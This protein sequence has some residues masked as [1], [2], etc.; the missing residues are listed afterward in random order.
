[1]FRM[2]LESNFPDLVK[3]IDRLGGN[4]RSA[5]REALNRSADDA[6]AA[7]SLEIDRAFDR[8]VNFTRKSLRVYYANTSNLVVRL[9]FRQRS[10]DEDKL[11]AFPQIVGGKRE[12][13]PFEKRLRAIGVLPQGW[14]A[15]PGRGATLD[16]YGNMDG[17]EISRILNV[18]GAYTESG[19]N[20]ANINT[21]KR[22]AKGVQ[23]KKKFRYG[24]EYITIPIGGLRGRRLLPGVYKRVKTGFGS[25]LVPMLIFIR[26]ATY[27]P[28]LRFERVVRD[29]FANKM[30]PNFQRALKSIQLTGSASG[31][32]RGVRLLVGQ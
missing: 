2:S 10:Q 23:G 14:L 26:S 22:L 32:R 1:M 29:E 20:K 6:S 12:L 31:I 30:Q 9:W 25:S 27:K 4:A 15:V 17:G 3:E 24:F 16:A 7:M 19:F 21:R 18:L 8:P 11:W 28:L 5:A 13:K